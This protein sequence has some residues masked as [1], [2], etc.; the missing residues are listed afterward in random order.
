MTGNHSRLKNFMRKFIGTVRF[1]NDH[2]GA[3]MGYG[4]YVIGDTVIS[5]VYY[6]EGLRHNLFSIGQFCDSDLK[7]AFRKHLCYVR[8][9]DGVE[10]LNGNRGSNL[11]TISV[12]DMMKSSPICLLSKASKNKSWLWHRQLN[13]L[14]FGTM[15][16]LERKDLV[17]GLPRLKFEKYHLCSACQLGKSKKYTYKPKSENT[18][19]E[20]LHTLHMDLCG[21]MRVQSIN[22][23]RYILVIVDDYSNNGTEFVNQV[24]TEFY[25]SVSITQQNGVVERQNRTL[26]EATRTMLI[27]SKAPMFL[28]L[29]ALAIACYTQNRSL[30]HTRYNKTPY[31]LVYGNKPDLTFLCVFGALYYLTNDNEDL[32]KLKAKVDIGIFV[33]YAPNRKGSEARPTFKDNPFSHADNDPFVNVF[34]PEPSS[35]ESSSGEDL[36]CKCRQQEHDYLPDG[37]QGCISEWRVERRSLRQSTR[38]FIDPNHPIHVYRL[39]KALYGLKQ[40]PRAWYQATPI[41]NHLEEIKWVFRYL[42]ETINMGLWYPKDTLMSLTAYADADHA[43][44]QDTRR[45]TSGSAQFLG[46]KLVSW[47]S[48]KQKSTAISTTEAEYIAMSGCC[49]QILWMRSQLMDYGF[50]FNN[51][52]LYCDNKSAIA[53]C[54]NNVQHSRSK[55]IDI[56]HHF[57]RKQVENAMVELYFVTT[58]YQLLD[59]FT[60]ALLRERFKFLLP[61]LGMKSMS[62]ETLKRLQKGEDAY[63]RLQLA[64]QTEETMSSKR[65]L[66]L[67]TVVCCETAALRSGLPCDLGSGLL[68]S[69]D[70]MAEENV[71]A[72]TRTDE[73]LVPVNQR[74][75]IGKEIFSWIFKRCRRILSLKFWNTL[76]KDTKTGVYSFQLDELWFNLNAD[77]LRN[78]LGITPKYSAHPFVPP[79]AG[80]LPWRTILF[81]INE[82]LTG[83]TSGGD[84]PRHLVLQMLWGIV[85]RTNVDYAELIWEEFIQAI[86]NLFSGLANLT[87]PTK[88]PKPPVI[89]YCC[90]PS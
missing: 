42:I 30:I 69:L 44:C 87:N 58:D 78:A 21:P 57:I 86:N 15:N 73:Q 11:Y 76:A 20:V 77:L 84:R 13:H 26:V 70:K 31:E 61:R 83:K 67:T 46:D 74:L 64:F 79:P 71:P 7:V 50:E 63:F 75:P 82:F 60:K 35:E 9:V 32:G 40:A 90:S 41:K 53:L 59:I 23:K 54:C 51:I 65:Q 89:P 37:C 4:D 17:R 66:F 27:F 62:L 3:I 25:E 14:N 6:V 8:D 33:G 34:A 19:M 16:D 1:G 2:F 85:T 36:H 24:L 22:G 43:G 56:R 52:P 5:T 80:D 49:A 28:W 72:P 88:K 10:S 29:E 12:K 38:G 48:K 39:K 68:I 55:H 81:T 45:S 18:I 47:S